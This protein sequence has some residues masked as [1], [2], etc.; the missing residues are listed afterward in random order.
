MK[1]WQKIFIFVLVFIILVIDLITFVFIENSRKLLIEKEKGQVLVELDNFNNILSQNYF[2]FKKSCCNSSEANDVLEEAFNKTIMEQKH[3]PNIAI[4]KDNKLIINTILE[5]EELFNNEKFEANTFKV[6]VFNNKDNFLLSQTI[7]LNNEQY[8]VVI[9]KDI[10]YIN[11]FFKEQIKT[12]TIILIIMTVL[13][14][15]FVLL[16]LMW[17]LR[18]INSIRKI[19]KK[20]ENKD[21]KVRLKVK[22]NDELSQLSKDINNTI[23]KIETNIEEIENYSKTRQEFIGNFAH[24][25]KTPL[26]SI[27]GYT[28]ILKIK[29]LT[30]AEEKKYINVIFEEAKRLKILSS[31]LLDINSM[32][33]NKLDLEKINLADFIEQIKTSIEPLLINKNIELSYNIPNT[34]ILVDKTLFT[35]LFYNIIENSIKASSINNKI[36][37]ECI[38][39]NKKVIITV[40][41]EGL[42]ISKDEINRI[43]EPFYMVDKARSRK[44]GGVGLG[45]HLCNKIVSLHKGELKIDSEIG[46]GTKIYLIFDEEVIK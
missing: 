40:E 1:I 13:A 33:N 15:L 38:T 3:L 8:I 24:E 43:I 5:Y 21:Y 46:K 22:G 18:P 23:D 14:S 7:D 42:G 29:K 44:N 41:D 28:D 45:L 10:T 25:M 32:D 34:Y 17:I 37:I 11:D 4:Y 27:L 9:N 39:K 6:K 30:K 19:F 16:L 36:T 20:I 12:M 2:Y 31:K 26:T 35:S